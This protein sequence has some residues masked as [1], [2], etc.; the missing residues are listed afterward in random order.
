MPGGETPNP[1]RVAVPR[2]VPKDE[3]IWLPWVLPG[4]AKHQTG[5]VGTARGPRLAAF[6]IIGGSWCQIHP[7]CGEEEPFAQASRL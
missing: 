6:S 7:T 5:I 4:S 2:G 1:T 3:S